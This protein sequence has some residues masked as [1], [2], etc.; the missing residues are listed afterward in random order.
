MGFVDFFSN[1]I[2]FASLQKH[3]ASPRYRTTVSLVVATKLMSATSIAP[4]V[5]IKYAPNERFQ[6]PHPEKG[7]AQGRECDT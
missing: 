4:Q 7:S 6:A 1:M 3:R 5:R 2:F